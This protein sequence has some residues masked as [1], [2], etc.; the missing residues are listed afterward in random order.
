MFRS[1]LQS[2]LLAGLV[3]LGATVRAADPAPEDKVR[4]E[5]D[6]QMREMVKSPPPEVVLSFEGLAQ[7]EG[8]KLVEADFTLDDQPLAVPGADTLN[9]AGLHRLA[10]TQVA[11]GSHTLV[12]R[13]TYVNDSWSL[14]SETSGRLWKMTATVS[15][16]AQRGLRVLVKVV[17][18][19]VPNAP[20]PRLK[21][22]LSHAVSVEMTAPLEDT[23]PPEPVAEAT[24]AQPPVSPEGS[25]TPQAG[26][27]QAPARP[28]K[29]MLR[30]TAKKRPVAAT[31]VVKGPGGARQVEL[32]PKARKPTRLELTPGT[33]TVEVIA[34]GFLA[35]SR[36]VVV[37]GRR[38][39][40]AQFALVRAPV[41]KTQQARLLGER[42]EL[43]RAPRFSERQSQPR[44]GT[45]GGLP[46]LVDALVRDTVLRV[47]IEG[48]TDS[49]ESTETARQQLAEARARAVAALLVRAGVDPA[50][51][52]TAGFGDSLP[53]APNLTA[54][55]RQ[56][57][58]RVE[59]IL[60]R[61]K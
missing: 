51:I 32:D 21:V 28:A 52:V 1:A 40:K 45:T 49:R 55:G 3:L 23:T 41:R 9:G 8:F 17:P 35:Q 29:L 13:V 12:S 26:E 42:F 27:V 20:D 18:G 59:F 47:R 37:G 54:P 7:A 36:R 56:L 15:F 11:E 2:L 6:R 61:G 50:R 33:Y 19:I 30:V 39:A 16:Q 24:P 57:N 14:F 10:M 60:V 44:K 43:P 53:R 34:K 4:E 31:V 5:L 46:L 25:G 58:R 48:H 22:K 38:E